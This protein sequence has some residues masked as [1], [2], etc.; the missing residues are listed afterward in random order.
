M[1]QNQVKCKN[2]SMTS[3]LNIYLR[4]LQKDEEAERERDLPDICWT[5]PQEA[6][7]GSAGPA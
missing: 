3:F 6:T 7:V 5:A 1:G 4:D 2:G